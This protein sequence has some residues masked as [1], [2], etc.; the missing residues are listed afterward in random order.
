MS[1]KSLDIYRKYTE[2]SINEANK[3]NKSFS[4]NLINKS[5][6]T[7]SLFYSDLIQHKAILHKKPKNMDIYSRCVECN[8]ERSNFDTKNTSQFYADYLSFVKA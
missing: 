1:E 2:T 4:K 8:V 3:M 6:N 5:E 7:N